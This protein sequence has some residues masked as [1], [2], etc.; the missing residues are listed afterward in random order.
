MDLGVGFCSEKDQFYAFQT[1]MIE[2]MPDGNFAKLLQL[3]FRV[4]FDSDETKPK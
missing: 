1:D 3:Y 4:L 2:V